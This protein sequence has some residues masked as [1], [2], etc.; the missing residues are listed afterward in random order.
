MEYYEWDAEYCEPS[1]FEEK[2]DE[3]KE[4]IKQSARKE[5]NDEL[6]KLKSENASMKSIV[7]NFNNKLK[8]LEQEKQKY[9]WNENKLKEEI[10]RQIKNERLGNLLDG[11]QTTLYT[12]INEGRERPKCNKCDK[13]RYIHFKSPSGKD[14][15]ERCECYSSNNF[16]VVKEA[17]C[18]EFRICEFNNNNRKGKLTGWYK[19][20]R[21]R[22]NDYDYYESSDYA[23]DSIYNNQPFKEINRNKIY[24]YDKTK[25]QEYADW[26]NNKNNKGE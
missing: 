25:A 6:I 14:M 18:K 4:M 12:I 1:E 9:I 15:T 26:L 24:F 10:T 21:A 17:E 11:F 8:E 7:D 23:Y 2:C 20:R 13:D 16:Y 3:L 22:D 19:L 5:I